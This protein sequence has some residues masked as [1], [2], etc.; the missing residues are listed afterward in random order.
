[1]FIVRESQL[2][3]EYIHDTLCR[4]LILYTTQDLL[5]NIIYS[6]YSIIISER[7]SVRL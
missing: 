7:I 3:I 1:M 5:C 2:S 6:S 4:Y